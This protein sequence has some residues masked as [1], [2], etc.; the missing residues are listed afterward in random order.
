MVLL[1]MV[2]LCM[3]VGTAQF[4]DNSSQR[5]THI[6]LYRV[7]GTLTYCR[8]Y[9]YLLMLT[10]NGKACSAIMENHKNCPQHLD[11]QSVIVCPSV[12]LGLT[13]VKFSYSLMRHRETAVCAVK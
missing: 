8:G 4:M 6:Q 7:A 12:R 1:C 11:H 2:L 10:K 9:T 13:M 5:A 3:A